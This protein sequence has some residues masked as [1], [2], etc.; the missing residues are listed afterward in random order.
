M[1]INYLI[2]LLDVVLVSALLDFISFASREL[3]SKLECDIL[4]FLYS[5]YY[6]L[7]VVLFI[8]RC[9]ISPENLHSLVSIS[10]NSVIYI[11]VYHCSG[12]ILIKMLVY[13][14]RLALLFLIMV[15]CMLNSSSPFHSVWLLNY[16]VLS[17]WL[18]WRLLDGKSSAVWWWN[19]HL[20]SKYLT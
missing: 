19:S 17:C 10:G 2:M 14:F 6:L 9:Y 18:Q 4:Y 1:V 20:S 8:T 15:L 16:S 12:N 13:V 3:F 7:C 11:Y 5:K